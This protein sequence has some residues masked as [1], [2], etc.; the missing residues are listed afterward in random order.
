[1][2]AP[3]SRPDTP[4]QEHADISRFWSKVDRRGADECWPWLAS[5][6]REHG[7]F[8]LQ[9]KHVYAHRFAYE[10]LVGPILE[11]HVIDHLCKRK[12]CVNP[13]HLESVTRKVNT[14]R[15]TAPPAENHVKTYC[16][17]GHE[18]T[19]ENTYWRAGVYGRECRICRLNNNARRRARRRAERATA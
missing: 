11:G 8:W 10:I 3:S 1:M 2:T 15:G 9:G 12:D 17:H 6:N 14:L 4:A 18:F 5:T 13:S 7:Q 19:E 16:K